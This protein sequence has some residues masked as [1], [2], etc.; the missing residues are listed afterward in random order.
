LAALAGWPGIAG[1]TLGVIDYDH[2]FRSV[3][4][5]RDLPATAR[6]FGAETV[7]GTI[8][9]RLGFMSALIVDRRMWDVVCR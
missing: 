5:I 3:I 8:A 7:F 2:E 9:D 6:I 1:M 4:G